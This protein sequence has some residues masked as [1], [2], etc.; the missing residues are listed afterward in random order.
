MR[1]T[2]TSPQ[3]QMLAELVACAGIAFVAKIAATL[4]LVAAVLMFAI[5][6]GG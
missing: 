5:A 1:P 4:A 6:A 3:R 2:R